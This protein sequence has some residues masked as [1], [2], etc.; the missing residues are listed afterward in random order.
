MLKA[1]VLMSSIHVNDDGPLRECP[2][3]KG[4]EVARDE[5]QVLPLTKLKRARRSLLG[6]IEHAGAR[7]IITDYGE[8][9]AE[10]GP[11]SKEAG[12][13]LAQRQLEDDAGDPDALSGNGRNHFL[14]A[15]PNLERRDGSDRLDS[16]RALNGR[17]VSRRIR[18]S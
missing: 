13:F 9:V 15:H 8:A 4:E 6:K 17:P 10:L 5:F 18:S 3:D 2:H 1:V 11:V 12:R 16:P 14:Q 7:F